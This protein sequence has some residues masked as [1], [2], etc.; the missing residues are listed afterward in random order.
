MAEETKTTPAGIV[1]AAPIEGVAIGKTLPSDEDVGF[2]KRTYFAPEY[3]EVNVPYSVQDKSERY[4]SS[5]RAILWE[6]RDGTLYAIG[7]APPNMARQNELQ[8]YQYIAKQ[9]DEDGEFEYEALDRVNFKNPKD[10]ELCV[11]WSCQDSVD[12]SKPRVDNEMWRAL[13]GRG[14][15]LFDPEQLDAEGDVF[16]PD[17]TVVYDAE[18]AYF[19]ALRKARRYLSHWN[20]DIVRA[21]AIGNLTGKP[22]IVKKRRSF[23]ASSAPRRVGRPRPGTKAKVEPPKAK[24]EPPVSEPEQAETEQQNALDQ[25]QNNN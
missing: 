19:E 20:N 9:N 18:T 23:T 17:G 15:L 2:K 1:L 25:E 16:Y 11:I 5:H 10:L 3:Y 12:G 21:L 7:S 14:A 22:R 4:E 8:E 6:D 13:E 24:A